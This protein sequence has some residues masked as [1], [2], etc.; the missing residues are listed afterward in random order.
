MSTFLKKEEWKKI[1]LKII[2]RRR[3][4]FI[5]GGFEI[6]GQV[7]NDDG[8]CADFLFHYNLNDDGERT[9]WVKYFAPTQMKSKQRISHPL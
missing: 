9:I 7:R 2:F 5:N 6:A 1:R 3:F 4:V 8:V